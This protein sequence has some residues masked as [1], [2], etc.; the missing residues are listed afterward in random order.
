V[1]EPTGV[2]L[3]RGSFFVPTVAEA[4]RARHIARRPATGDRRR[5]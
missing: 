5:A 1:R 4:A 3:L 2:L